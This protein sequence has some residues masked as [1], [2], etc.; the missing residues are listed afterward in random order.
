MV[1]GPVTTSMVQVIITETYAG[2]IDNYG[3]LELELWTAETET[4][5][6]NNNDDFMTPPDAANNID[7]DMTSPDEI[8]ALHDIMTST[9]A[10]FNNIFRIFSIT[11]IN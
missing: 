10:A 3:F 5:L 9:K 6:S 4:T 8:D 11:Y 1:L 7:D 2:R